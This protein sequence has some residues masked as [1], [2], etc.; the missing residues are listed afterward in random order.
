MSL[1]EQDP[2]EA[3]VL[4]STQVPCSPPT[5]SWVQRG[6]SSS[7]AGLS[8]RPS[9]TAP[10]ASTGDATSLIPP[11]LISRDRKLSRGDREPVARPAFVHPPSPQSSHLPHPSAVTSIPVQ[12]A[13]DVVEGP[14]R[15]IPSP[16]ESAEW[17]TS[18]LPAARQTRQEEFNRAASR[19]EVYD[20]DAPSLNDGKARKPNA[21]D[22]MDDDHEESDEEQEMCVICLQGVRDRTVLGEC[23]HQCFCVSRLWSYQLILSPFLPSHILI[24]RS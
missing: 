5:I 19:G 18:R 2:A 22:D 12:D 1:F 9:G 8:T 20:L 4:Q 24:V 7:Q 3:F 23:G 14:I 17:R 13:S 21:V 15:R 16:E 11:A 6:G 10:G